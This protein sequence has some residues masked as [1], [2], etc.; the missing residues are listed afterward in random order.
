MRRPPDTA[1]ARAA[2]WAWRALRTARARLRHGEVRGV[3]LPAPP[4]VNTS[5]ARAV[6]LVLNVTR[7]S[8]LER[9]LVL[10]RWLA[11]HGVARDVIVGTEGGTR[12]GFTA[13]AWLEGETLP[14]GRSYVELIRLSP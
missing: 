13:H 1:D 8:C 9:S 2:L 4:P 12:S 7:A 6:R 10:Q 14:P 3:R 11:S 5:G